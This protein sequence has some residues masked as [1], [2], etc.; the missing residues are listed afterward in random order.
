MGTAR[1]LGADGEHKGLIWSYVAHP[2]RATWKAD[3]D[4][5]WTPPG[6]KSGPD[7]VG[8][9]VDMK[10]LDDNE[11]W[12]AAQLHKRDRYLDM[13]RAKVRAGMLR[14]SA[15]FAKSLGLD[16]SLYGT[17]G[18]G[19]IKSVALL[20]SSY[21]PMAVKSLTEP[22]IKAL[23]DAGLRRFLETGDMAAAIGEIRSGARRELQAANPIDPDTGLPIVR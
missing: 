12:V 11:T 20:D 4:V 13:I 23:A 16:A 6:A 2:E 18:P 9:V 19:T 17:S 1:F 22:D 21:R 7:R 8:E 3:P 5:L 14:V 15:D 10:E